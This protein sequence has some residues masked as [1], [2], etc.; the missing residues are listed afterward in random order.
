MLRRFVLLR[1]RRDFQV[2][3]YSRLFFAVAPQHERLLIPVVTVVRP[4]EGNERERPT[5]DIRGSSNRR[6]R[7][8]KWWPDSPPCMVALVR[9][10][11]SNLVTERRST[12]CEVF[13]NR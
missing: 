3:R 13:G 10:S 6:G 2:R 7:G 8:R 11:H 5:R 4:R 12:P 1:F 9:A